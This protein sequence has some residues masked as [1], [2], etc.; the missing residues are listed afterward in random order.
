[1]NNDE[2]IKPIS[3][4]GLMTRSLTL[5]AEMWDFIARLA[6]ENQWSTSHVVREM[7]LENMSKKDGE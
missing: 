5:T 3:R 4:K 6:D 7:I 2:S 1:M